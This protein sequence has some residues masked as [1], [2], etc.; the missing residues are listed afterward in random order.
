MG[1][2]S[3]AVK[4][5]NQA[6][7]AHNTATDPR[8]LTTSYQLF[9]SACLADP[10]WYEGHFQAGN[11]NS[12]L[13]HYEAAIANWRLALQCE[14]TKDEKVRALVNLGWRLHSLA[15]TDEALAATDAALK[16]DDTHFLG[17]L[18]MSLI[19]SHL[20][21]SV[22]MQV[23]AEKCWELCPKDAP[24][25]ANC[26]IAVAF[27]CLFNGDYERGFK[28]FERR[29]EWRLP[30]FLKF[31]Y[32]KWAGQPGKTVFVAADQGLG[33]TL[34]FA[35]FVPAA[36]KRARYLHLFIQP[37]LLR[38]FAHAFA[39]LPNVNLIPAPAPFP[40]ADYWTTFVSLSYALGLT[41]KEVTNQKH[42]EAPVFGMPRTWKVPDKK[43]H[44]GIAWSGSPANDIDRWRNIPLTQFFE[45]LHVPGVQLYSFQKDE[46]GKELH[47]AG[48]AGFIRDLTPY[49]SDVADTVS[50]L[51]DL[52]LV[53]CCES[54]LGHIAALVGRECWIPYSWGGRDYRVG[55]AGEKML[56][57]PKTRIFRQLQG[58]SWSSV[59]KEITSALEDKLN[60]QSRN[61]A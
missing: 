59:F 9:S 40:A 18:N 48:A 60:E 15:R 27:A 14:M 34:S 8:H 45:L 5:Y 4:F 47:D 19:R 33:D 49:I 11:N 26:E 46:K 35:R 37:A 32:E 42:I 54:A 23:A 56:W 53:I 29:F 16:L 10:T 55:L 38:L 50:L 24:E 36:A 1:N 44:V 12:N 3:E 51:R 2:R 25:N 13:N 20:C 39:H 43:L 28:H 31:P 30:Q 57:T 52:D 61:A 7:E 22:H 41:N 17:W 21:D 58:E 6:V